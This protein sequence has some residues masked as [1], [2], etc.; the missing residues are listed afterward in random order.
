MNI[1]AFPFYTSRNKQAR[2]QGCRVTPLIAPLGR[3]LPFMLTLPLTGEGLDCVN[4]YDADTDDVISYV[5]PDK[6]TFDVFSDG[7]NDFVF[8]Y[9][10]V[11]QGLVM[12]CG[13]RYYLEAKG[14]FSEVFQVTDELTKY[15]QLDWKHRLPVQGV[16]YQTGFVNR[17]YLDAVIAEPTYKTTE[18]GDED[19]FGV[20]QPTR[21]RIDKVLKFDTLYLPEFLV[22]ALASVPLH[23]MVNIGRYYD[24]R[25]IK[26]TPDWSKDGCSAIIT[27]N[28]SN[29]RPIEADYCGNL[30]AVTAV[31]LTGYVPM[32][33]VCD[34][35]PDPR[36]N[37]VDVPVPLTC[38]VVNGRNTG[39]REQP[40]VDQNINSPTYSQTRQ[41][42]VLDSRCPVPVQ[43]TSVAISEVVQ[44]NDCDPGYTGD[45]VTYTLPAGHIVD[46]TSQV[47]VDTRAQ[48]YFDSTKQAFANA[49]TTCTL[50]GGNYT[51]QYDRYG[52][53]TGL[54]VE[55]GTGNTRGADL[56]ECQ[57]CNAANGG[58]PGSPC[59]GLDCQ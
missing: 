48:A 37:W 30:A 51:C 57:S 31:D 15:L 44:R 2:F 26:V 49:N 27:F 4:V 11:V 29:D 13:G 9:G 25:Q 7:I 24:C 14:Q 39:F 40:Q 10:G 23:S 34:G 35:T 46:I 19:G 28:F 58:T 47:D 36:P 12:P 20:F 41:R 38:I 42:P 22:D 53:W 3:W 55:A 45:S 32:I 5:T 59:L 54:M 1:L 33:W 8:Y 18:E 52:C 16:I 43:Y 21:S 56:A 6:F 50:D 17:L